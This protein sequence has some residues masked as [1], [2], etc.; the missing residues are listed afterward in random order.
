ML[1][2]PLQGSDK[3][4]EGVWALPRRRQQQQEGHRR[5]HARSVRLAFGSALSSAWTRH[6][7]WPT[8]VST[9]VSTFPARAH[10]IGRTHGVTLLRPRWGNRGPRGLVN[11]G[12]LLS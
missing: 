2:S 5:G 11:V 4:G 10:L 3:P 12:K 7:C 1:S 8:F 6:P 9:A